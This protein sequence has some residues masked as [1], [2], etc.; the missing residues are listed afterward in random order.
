MNR[1]KESLEAA[2]K[3]NKDLEEK[4]TSLEERVQMLK[5]EGRHQLRKVTDLD[6]MHRLESRRQIQRIS[7]LSRMVSK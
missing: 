4:N 7:E 6:Q 1:L 2:N 3:A 5:E